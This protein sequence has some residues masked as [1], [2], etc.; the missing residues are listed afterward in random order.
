MSVIKARGIVIK[1]Q[2]NGEAGKLLTLLIKG[3]GRAMASARGARR[4]GS[5]IAAGAQL[6]TYSDFVFFKRGDFLSLTQADVIENFYALR[7]DYDRLRAGSYL[8]E[9]CDRT[10][11]ENVPCDDVMYLL[12][13]TLLALSRGKA[14]PDLA[15]R[16]FEFKF[17]A[18]MGMAPDFS[19]CARCGREIGEAGP[20]LFAGDGAVCAACANERNS[21]GNAAALVRLSREAVNAARGFVES[22]PDRLFAA[23]EMPN[24]AVLAEL[25]RAAGAFIQNHFDIRLKSLR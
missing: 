19:R 5:K 8:L 16:A 6:F 17:F 25:E 18:Y 14:S 2:D 7:T 1:E 12:L 10:I 15:A 24:A 11:M 22:Q 23:R 3:S 4:Q 20:V 9:L 13:K 21:A